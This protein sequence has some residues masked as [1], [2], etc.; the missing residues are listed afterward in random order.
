MNYNK[1]F[2]KKTI[3]I[4]CMIFIIIMAIF[5]RLNIGLNI[6]FGCVIVYMII[7][8]LDK[9]KE[10]DIKEDNEIEE[11]K[12]S[13]IQPTP[14]LLQNYKDII[15]FLFSIQDY[16]KYNPQTYENIVDNLDDFFHLY[17]EVYK[18][19]NLAG[20][21][22]KLMNTIKSDTINTLHS[23]IYKL[24]ED[25]AY[26][27]KLNLSFDILNK[28]LSKYLYDI[29]KINKSNILNKGYN[30]N[31]IIINHNEPT[32]YSTYDKIYGKN[33]DFF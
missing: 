24:P 14:S 8:K 9:Q 4:Y 1:N 7:I 10:N 6:V 25:F 33:Y 19:N 31:T 16:Y 2:D 3:F 5:Y 22:Y 29:Y 23:L 30:I 13:L 32:P 17:E 11:L 20:T 28:I 21:N 18:L 15:N 27:N 26:I 12:T